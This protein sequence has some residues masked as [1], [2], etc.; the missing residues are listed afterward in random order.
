MLGARWGFASTVV[1]GS[2]A[3]IARVPVRAQ[4]LVRG[5]DGIDVVDA[6]TV[7]LS[8]TVA[9]PQSGARVPRSRVQSTPK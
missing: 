1:E 2:S 4:P 8:L 3:T 7:A 5:V 6:L 9:G